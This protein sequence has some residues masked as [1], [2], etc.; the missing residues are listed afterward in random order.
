MLALSNFDK[1]FK[2]NCDALD[3]AL[4]VSLANMVGA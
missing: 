1:L 4:E 3:L 2:M